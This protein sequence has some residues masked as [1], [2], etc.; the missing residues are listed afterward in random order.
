MIKQNQKIMINWRTRVWNYHNH[1]VSLGS[2]RFFWN[3][4]CSHQDQ[5]DIL[6]CK[7]V[8][9][10]YIPSFCFTIIHLIAITITFVV[11]WV[12]VRPRNRKARISINHHISTL[13]GCGYES[14]VATKIIID[15]VLTIT[16]NNDTIIRIQE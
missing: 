1:M 16:T 2:N 13:L 10:T 4:H 8:A 12:C 9:K 5:I 7:L 14:A 6:I 11:W 3:Y 15:Y